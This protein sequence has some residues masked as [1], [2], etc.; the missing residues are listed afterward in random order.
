MVVGAV[1]CRGFRNLAD[2]STALAASTIVVHGAERSRQDQ[3]ARGGLLRP[4]RPLVP[5]RQRSRPDPPRRAGRPG[6]ARARRGRRPAGRAS[7]APASAG[8][9]LSGRPSSARS[10]RAAAG[11]RLPSGS[12][13]ARQGSTGPPPGP[14]RPSLWRALAGTGRPAPA[15]RAHPGP[16]QRTGRARPGRIGRSR[17]PA[18]LGRATR[19]RGGAPDRVPRGRGR[20]PRP[21]RS[22]AGRPPRPR[23]ARRSPIG[24]RAAAD[25]AELAAE[26]TRRRAEDLGRAYTSYG[27]QLDEVELRSGGPPAAPLRLAGPAAPGAAGVALRRAGGAARCRPVGTADAARRR[28]ER[29]RPRSSGA[30]RV[31][32]RAG[33]D[34]SR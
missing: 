17:L 14:S 28:D 6:G 30:A 22:R 34:R 1:E 8:S 26:L 12:A 16:A 32:A 10:R 9:S 27:P 19:A 11:Q 33:A 13:G 31:P 25:A 7:T 2:A 5:R 23:R 18:L 15:F 4:H 29:A 24:P 3:P 21:G 20:G